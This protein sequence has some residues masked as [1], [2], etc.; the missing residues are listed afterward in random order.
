VL[1]GCAE[2]ARQG[3]LTEFVQTAAALGPVVFS[4]TPYLAA[5]RSLHRGAPLREEVARRFGVSSAPQ[6]G[7]R[8]AL[9]TDTFSGEGLPDSLTQIRRV[10][11]LLPERTEIITCDPDVSPGREGWRNFQPVGSFALPGEQKLT[12]SF[13]PFLE[14]IEYLERR[15]FE[16]VYLATPGPVGL[17]GLL[18]AHLLALP[19]RG[20][21]RPE[22]NAAL[23]GKLGDPHLDEL[24]ERFTAWYF[25]QLETLWVPGSQGTHQPACQPAEGASP[26]S[27][28]QFSEA[29][30]SNRMGA[31][32]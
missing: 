11:R 26:W 4:I 23:V 6:D 18:G 7:P 20:L 21:Y 1:R 2:H 30:E 17:S 13:P 3:E 32:G 10:A 15:E 31:V 28:E 12:V 19:A 8:R 29:D 22:L 14:I 5:F 16:E 27:R 9:V 25:G 24:M